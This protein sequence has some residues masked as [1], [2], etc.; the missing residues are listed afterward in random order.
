M[1]VRMHDFNS[2]EGLVGTGLSAVYLLR[3]EAIDRP[4]LGG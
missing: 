2:S 3:H 4:N 1:Q